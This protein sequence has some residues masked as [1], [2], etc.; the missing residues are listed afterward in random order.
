[1][2]PCPTTAAYAGVHEV[3]PQCLNSECFYYF[4]IFLLFHYNSKLNICMPV[5]KICYF[6]NEVVGNS[7]RVTSFLLLPK[8]FPNG[9]TFLLPAVVECVKVSHLV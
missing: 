4:V 6:F 5:S 3:W 8:A 1:M 2:C 9:Y 7:S